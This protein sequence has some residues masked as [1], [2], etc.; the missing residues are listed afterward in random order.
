M[1]N[2]NNIDD[3][4][5]IDLSMMNAITYGAAAGRVRRPGRGG[6]IKG[7]DA[8]DH[9]AGMLCGGLIVTGDG[10]SLVVSRAERDTLTAKVG[11]YAR[12]VGGDS[13]SV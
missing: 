5:T 13:D 9:G 4:V 11:E 8:A 6:T 3:G 12:S 2:S 7:R 10:A 1:P